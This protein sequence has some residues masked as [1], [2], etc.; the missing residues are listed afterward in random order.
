[1]DFSTTYLGLKLRSPLVLSACPLTQEVD[2]IKRAEDSG[3]GAIVPRHRAPSSCPV[4]IAE[5]QQALSLHSSH[6]HAR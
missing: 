1:M 3:A 2:D 4:M 5:P 6:A